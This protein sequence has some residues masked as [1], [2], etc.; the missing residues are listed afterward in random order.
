MKSAFLNLLKISAKAKKE[1]GLEFTAPEIAQQPAVW[2]KAAGQLRQKRK[3]ILDFMKKNGLAGKE[4]ATLIFAGAGTS[5]FVGNSVYQGLKAELKRETISIPT[6]H[7]VTHPATMLVKGNN[8]VVT[9]FARSGNSPESV[10]TYNIIRKF[11]PDA[12]QLVITCDRNGAL[13]RRAGSDKKEF[14][15]V[16]PDETN[17]K[18]LVMTS[19]FSTMAMAAMALGSINKMDAFERSVKI[20]AKAAQRVMGVYGNM[21]AGLGRRPFKRA[22]FLGSGNLYGTMQECHLKMQEMTEGRVACRFDSFLGLRHGPQVFINKECITVAAVSSDPYTRKYEL[23]L[24]K[25]LK[26]NK[27]GMATVII[28][29]KADKVIKALSPYIVEL[30]PGG[31]GINDK[32]RV[33]TDVV[34]GQVLA[35]FK[36]MA[37]GLKPDNP[38]TSGTI[39]RVVKGVTIYEKH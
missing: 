11:Y 1:R 39:N 22:C 31:K 30:C 19:S 18:S 10:A 4:K 24:L 3:A 34:V 7:F 32:L 15:I 26:K 36:C 9:S 8:Y 13:A 29:D 33:L 21:L 38:S 37:I 27:Q 17:D 23:D 5:E 35:T 25:Q 20:A 12:R 6:T 16:L 28:C 2:V 14:C